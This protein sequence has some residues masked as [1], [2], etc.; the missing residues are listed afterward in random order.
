MAIAGLRSRR[1]THGSRP[2]ALTVAC[3][4]SVG[5]FA[6]TPGGISQRF[7]QAM[8]ALHAGTAQLALELQR[9]PCSF[10]PAL[11]ARLTPEYVKDQR[12]HISDVISRLCR[13]EQYQ[14]GPG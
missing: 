3:M 8:A 9:K 2:T 6:A 13:Q 12:Q 1:L 14:P 4:P 7:S 11:Q 10:V 5:P